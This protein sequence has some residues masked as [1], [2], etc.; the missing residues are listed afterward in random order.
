MDPFLGDFAV[1]D[2]HVRAFVTYQYSIFA[3]STGSHRDPDLATVFAIDLALK[4]LHD[5][6]LFHQGLER[7]ATLGIG[8]DLPRNISDA[9]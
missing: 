8:V 2:V 6:L 5:S 3:H 1:R 7:L 9:C 4:V